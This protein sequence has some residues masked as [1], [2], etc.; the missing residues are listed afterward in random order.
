MVDTQI[1]CGLRK[2]KH[3]VKK[4]SFFLHFSS[5]IIKFFH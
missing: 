2:G 1:K 5:V 4:L 3:F